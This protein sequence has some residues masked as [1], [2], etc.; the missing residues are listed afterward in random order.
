MHLDDALGRRDDL[1]LVFNHHEQACAIAAEGYARATGGIGVACVTTGPG[2]HERDHRRPRAVARLGPGALRLRAGAPRHDRRQHRPAAAPA[3]RPGGRH[4]PPGR[5]DHQVRRLG[6]RPGDGALPLREG[7]SGWP[8]TAGPGPVWLDVPLNV[9]AAE[10]DP[11]ALVGFDPARAGAAM[12]TA[13]RRATGR[14]RLRS[15]RRSVGRGRRSSRPPRPPGAFSGRV[16]PRGRAAAARETLRRLRAAERPVILAGS[17]VRA[18]GALRR[19]LRVVDALG[20]PVCTAWNALRPAAGRITRSSSG[21]RA[22]S[23]TAPATSRCRTPT[24]SLVLGCRLNVRQIGYEFAAFAHH[25]Y[26][27]VVDIDEAE[28]RQAD[29]LPGP[30]RCTPTS[31]SSSRSSTRAG[32]DRAACAARRLGSRGAASGERRYPVVLPEYRRR[33]APVEPVRLRR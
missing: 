31:A 7:A 8:R 9:Q 2:R 3:R 16:R 23:A 21:G 12:P 29:D 19:F 25:A 6:H 27:I 26:R 33:R 22:A 13:R 28:L 14:P 1:E 17:G 10:V 30:A 20:V 15:R 24:S 5:A 32:G 4:R 11:D 18:A